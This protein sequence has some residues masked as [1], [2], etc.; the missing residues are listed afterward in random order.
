MSAAEEDALIARSIAGDHVA[1]AVLVRRHGPRLARSVRALGVLPGDVEDVVQDAFVAAWR[2]LASFKLG[3]SFI[4]W[5][6]V[7]AAN[8]ARDWSR[9]RR[10]AFWRQDAADPGE[11][12]TVADPTTTLQALG[13]RDELR[14]LS[15]RLAL[16]PYPQRQALVLVT[17]GGLTHAEAAEALGATSKAIEIRIARARAKLGEEANPPPLS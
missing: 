7:I 15:R 16:L 4:A 1:F 11:A 5:A 12:A 2:S 14:S 9:G 17:V 10:L 3:M 6:S 13:A 8:K